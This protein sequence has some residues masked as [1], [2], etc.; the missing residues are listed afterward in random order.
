MLIDFKRWFLMND[1]VASSYGEV[2]LRLAIVIITIRL[3]IY[4]L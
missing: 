3:I 4:L 2:G 1:S